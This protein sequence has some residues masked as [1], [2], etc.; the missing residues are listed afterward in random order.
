MMVSKFVVAAVQHYRE[1]PLTG[2]KAIQIGNLADRTRSDNEA[3]VERLRASIGRELTR[4]DKKQY[5][6]TIE[7]DT[8]RRFVWLV[9]FAT[10]GDYRSLVG[11]C[12]ER[13]ASVVEDM[14]L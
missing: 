4:A 10:A 11:E 14:R 3:L 8:G 2:S 6:S 12:A 7:A 9:E 13:L 5:S 1:T